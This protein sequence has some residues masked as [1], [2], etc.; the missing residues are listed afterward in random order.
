[1]HKVMHML[2]A[3]GGHVELDENNWQAVVHEIK[4]ESGYVLDEL[5][6]LQ[7]A[8]RIKTLTS[9]QL[10][11]YPLVIKTQ[12]TTGL[13]N[14]LHDD[15]AYVFTTLKDP[16]IAIDSS[17]SDDIRW[18]TEQEIQNL[19]DESIYADTR[20]IYMYLFRVV[21]K[22]WEQIDTSIFS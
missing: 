12:D 7:P 10:Q 18:L 2:V 6:V 5:K 16:S 13:E 8:E 9:V 17:E 3:V 15:I 22:S 4:E 19:S 11:P 1:M 14:H 21:L 20:E